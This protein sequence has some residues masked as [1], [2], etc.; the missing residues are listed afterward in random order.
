M[1][2]VACAILVR[3]GQVLLGL[4]AAHRRWYPNFWDVIGG[5]L[6]PGETA[7]AALVRE[8]QEEIGVTPQTFVP[9]D[10]LPEPLPEL[11]GPAACHCFA[12]TRWSGGEPVMLGDEHAELRWFALEDACAIPNLALAGYPA[13]F[14]RAVALG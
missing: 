1:R 14:R 8:V 5:H 10:T 7:E 13:L 9:L 3:D 2:H 6:E 4:R 12:V 11:H